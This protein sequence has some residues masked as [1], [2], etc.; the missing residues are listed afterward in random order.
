MCLFILL[1]LYR[2]YIRVTPIPSVRR[3]MHPLAFRA[4]T[5]AIVTLL[6][7]P[8]LHALWGYWIVR[9]LLPFFPPSTT[10]LLSSMP[11]TL[12]YPSIIFPTCPSGSLAHPPCRVL[13]KRMLSPGCTRYASPP[14]SSQSASFIK[15]RIPGRLCVCVC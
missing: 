12:K 10:S 6:P 2:I 1:C 15:T 7:P 8:I 11:K 14:S 13:T 9:P 5:L 3:E 4:V